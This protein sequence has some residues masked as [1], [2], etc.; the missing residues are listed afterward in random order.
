MWCAGAGSIARSQD[1]RPSSNGLANLYMG[2]VAVA[3]GPV[4]AV[5]GDG[6]ADSAG[7]AAAASVQRGFPTN[8]PVDPVVRREEQTEG[9]MSPQGRL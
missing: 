6:D 5:V 2:G 3:E 4:V 1:L 7:V 8:G 9:Y